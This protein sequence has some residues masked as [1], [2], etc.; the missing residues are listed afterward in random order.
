L[1]EG[2]IQRA[3]SNLFAEGKSETMGDAEGGWTYQNCTVSPLKE[4]QAEA[5]GKQSAQY[6][7]G[8]GDGRSL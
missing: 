6:L 5:E 4:G 3:G 7:G 8:G 2:K 1:K